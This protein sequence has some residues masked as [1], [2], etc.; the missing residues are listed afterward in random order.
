MSSREKVQSF[1]GY[2]EFLSH[3]LQMP[4]WD[5]SLWFAISLLLPEPGPL[6]VLFLRT[7]AGY[8]NLSGTSTNRTGGASGHVKTGK[9]SMAH[10]TYL[11]HFLPGTIL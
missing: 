8:L 2:V 10:V 11:H 9:D 1:Q 5:G 4:C 3:F 6:H 7:K